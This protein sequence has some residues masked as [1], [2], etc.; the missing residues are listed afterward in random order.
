MSNKLRIAIGGIW[1]LTPNYRNALTHLGVE[2]A[3]G[4][5]LEPE[6][7]DGLIIP[8]G[9]DV[10]PSFYG[11]GING[12]EDIDIELDNAQLDIIDRFLSAGRPILGICRGEQILNVFFGGSLIQNL[13][14]A[15][16]HKR[17]HNG[18]RAHPTQ[19]E[20]GSFIADIYGTA[21]VVNSAHHQAVDRLGSGLKVVQMSDDNVI[22]AFYH[23]TLPVWGVQWHPERMCFEKKRSDTVDGSRVISFFLNKCI[24]MNK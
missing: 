22:E 19:A 8:G 16:R 5:D 1:E 18:D 2:Y 9:G 15:Y 10:D 11:Q 7:F 23:T 4:L 20:E 17:D 6:D 12:S 3:V 21:P 13:P 14:N 24:E